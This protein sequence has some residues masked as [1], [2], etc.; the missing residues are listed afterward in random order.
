MA[1]SKDRSLDT[2]DAVLGGFQLCVMHLHI[3][4]SWRRVFSLV[5][6]ATQRNEIFR[7]FYTGINT[8]T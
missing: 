7:A 3:A 8:E 1:G 6:Q 4:T 5:Y 2:E